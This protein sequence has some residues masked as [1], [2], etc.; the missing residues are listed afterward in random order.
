MAEKHFERPSTIPVRS[1]AEPPRMGEGGLFRWVEETYGSVENF[2]KGS[3][4]LRSVER[5]K[6]T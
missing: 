2:L 6:N 4:A 1:Q 3:D 5:E